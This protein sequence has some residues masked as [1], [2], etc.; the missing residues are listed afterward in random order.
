MIRALSTHASRTN[1]AGSLRVKNAKLSAIALVPA[2]AASRAP[3]S[4]PEESAKAAVVLRP[5]FGPERRRS[6]GGRVLGE[7]EQEEEL[8]IG[9]N[10]AEWWKSPSWVQVA[11]VPG[12]R[13]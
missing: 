10:R 5:W 4:V 13:T 7:E 2:M 8:E 11:G 12:M 9:G 3:P 1:S 6:I